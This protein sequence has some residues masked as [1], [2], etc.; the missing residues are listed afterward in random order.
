MPTIIATPGAADATSYVTRAECTTYLD[1][2]LNSSAWTAASN[3]DQ[4]RA[5][6]EATRTLDALTWQGSRVTTTQALQWPRQSVP[7]PDAPRPAFGTKYDTL[8]FDP[9]VIPTR[10]QSAT[11]ELAL[12]FLKAGTTDLAAL[13]ASNGIITE[14]VGPLSTTYATPAQRASGIARFPRV[15][16]LVG[17]LLDTVAGGVRMVRA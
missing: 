3:D 17:P 10:L 16:Q 6:I 9:T 8:Y 1:A 14:T 15:L 13:P 4:D 7:D 2:R 11:C 5:L 12:E